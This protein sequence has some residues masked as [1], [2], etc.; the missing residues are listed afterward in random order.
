VDHLLSARILILLVQ[1]LGIGRIIMDPLDRLVLLYNL[2]RLDENM[3]IQM[4]IQMGVGG[5]LQGVQVLR[6]EIYQLVLA[7][8]LL[9]LLV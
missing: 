8:H 4:D 9:D 2:K 6:N 1:V 7:L 5:G 3:D